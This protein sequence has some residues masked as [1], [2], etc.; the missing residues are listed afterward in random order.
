[1][2]I[3]KI[4]FTVFLAAI[5]CVP[6]LIGISYYISSSQNPVTNAA[7]TKLEITTP[8]GAVFVYNKGDVCKEESIGENLISYFVGINERASFVME[9]PEIAT[10]QN[11]FTVDYTAYNRKTT[12]EY[13]FT[14][15]SS[16][17]YLKKSDG[18]VY[19]ITEEDAVAFL[20]SSFSHS[21]YSA[22]AVPVFTAGGKTITPFS[23]TWS[24][25][26]YDSEYRTV[27]VTTTTTLEEITVRGSIAPLFDIAPDYA[28]V[29]I[30]Q[31]DTVVYD[32]LLDTI[33]TSLFRDNAYY[34]V[35]LT[36]KWYQEP[37]TKE[38]FGEAVYQFRVKT[39]APAVFY[40]SENTVDPGEF[41][42]ITAKNVA[43]PSAITFTATPSIGFTPTFYQDG[44]VYRALVPISIG[45]TQ[46]PES[47]SFKLAYEGTEQTMQLNLNAK[48]FRSQT[49]DIAKEIIQAHRS[50][51]ALAEF[52]TVLGPVFS[53]RSE[54]KYFD[55]APF[56]DPAKGI[57]YDES[58]TR[59]GF[60]LTIILEA[61]GESYRH[62]GMNYVVTNDAQEV[63][64][65]TD[66][67]VVYVGEL[68]LTGKV[69]VIDHGFGLRSLL[70]HLDSYAVKVGDIVKKDDVIGICG[71]T[72]F[73]D[74]LALHYGLYVGSIP[75]C[76]YDML[77]HG[78]K[79]TRL[80][81]ENA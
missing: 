27:P 17:A 4:L 51:A 44:E 42:V 57:R 37:D 22:S 54:V 64:S 58:G 59:T 76:P 10:P 23:M 80:S 32:D 25:P 77:D 68:A 46:M 41:V 33:P 9:L 29:Q 3:N 2:K 39:L 55:A 45:I 73:T 72:G 40:L 31:N 12:Y 53:A 20:K 24:Y 61:T 5:I 56:S 67:K 71:D 6:G 69:V 19:R 66:G 35:K 43:D 26:C 28:S 13:Y 8:T 38:S 11:R 36:A 21:L 81:E 79:M 65:P 18:S 34:T 52:E 7:V 48:E 50:D 14:S 70:A 15:N 16:Y 75:V 30:T 74:E 1:M 78:V 47:F 62:E 63:I 60:G 49:H